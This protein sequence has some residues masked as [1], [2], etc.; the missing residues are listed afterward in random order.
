MGGCI[1]KSERH[2]TLLCPTVEW[3]I[4]ETVKLKIKQGLGECITSLTQHKPLMES[5][6]GYSVLSEDYRKPPIQMLSSHAASVS[7]EN[8]KSQEE[9]E[10]HSCLSKGER[11]AE[12]KTLT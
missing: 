10:G 2:C 9:R 7:L 12:K 11:G 4:S 1:C 6:Q 8:I 3:S 5:T